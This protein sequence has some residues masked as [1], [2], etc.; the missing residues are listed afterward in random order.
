MLC[1]SYFEPFYVCFFKKFETFVKATVI[2]DPNSSDE[3]YL[4][5]L[6]VAFLADHNKSQMD[7]N[8]NK[9]DDNQCCGSVTFGYGSGSADPDSAFFISGWQDANKK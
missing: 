8:D 5:I 1:W 4:L 9:Y 6:R 3:H 2:P 7:D